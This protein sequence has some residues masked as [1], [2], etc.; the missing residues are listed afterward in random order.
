MIRMKVQCKGAEEEVAFFDEEVITVGRSSKNNLQIPDNKASRRHFLFEKADKGYRVVDLGSKNGT[1]VNG[2]PVEAQ[3]LAKGDKIVTGEATIVVLDIAFAQQ[4]AQ[5]GGNVQPAKATASGRKKAA[6]AAASAPAP[7]K[8]PASQMVKD[9]KGAGGIN[10]HRG[11]REMP[12]GIFDYIL[13]VVIIILFLY[14]AGI[15]FFALKHRTEGT[16][17]DIE[18]ASKKFLH[19]E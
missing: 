1:R 14:I 7:P 19:Q 17:L 3:T 11:P 12:M 9:K 13:V 18:D 2:K 4:A 16:D 15:L 5:S 10:I 6:S 8:P